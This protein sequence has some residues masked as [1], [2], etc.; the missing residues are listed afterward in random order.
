MAPVPH[1]CPATLTLDKLQLDLHIGAGE[2]E[3]R[4]TQKIWVHLVFVFPL[5]PKACQSDKL[6]DTVCYHDICIKIKNYCHNKSFKL[7]ESLAY[8]LY[9]VLREDIDPTVTLSLTVEKCNPPIE[10]LVGSTRFTYSE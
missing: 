1:S 6:E 2:E 8:Q 3:R 4:T 7:I 10:G 5:P 9:V